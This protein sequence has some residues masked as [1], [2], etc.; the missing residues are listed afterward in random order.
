[1]NPG[2]GELAKSALGTAPTSAW[3][4]KSWRGNLVF[5]N[6]V[7]GIYPQAAIGISQHS[8]PVATNCDVVIDFSGT[9]A[10]PV[11]PPSSFFVF[12]Q[13][14]AQIDVERIYVA[15]YRFSQGSGFNAKYTPFGQSLQGF[16]SFVGA[17]GSTSYIIQAGGVAAG[18]WGIEA[19]VEAFTIGD[20]ITNLSIA[21]IVHGVEL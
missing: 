18:V 12:V 8:V 3:S 2:I 20:V 16:S 4:K 7:A 9:N 15:G 5:T 13:V 21:S 1:M 19:S 11:G 10:V 14:Y 17:P 6:T